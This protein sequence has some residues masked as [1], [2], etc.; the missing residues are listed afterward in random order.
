MPLE[1][2]YTSLQVGSIVL[3]GLTFIVGGG[4]IFTGIKVNRRQAILIEGLKRQNLE[5]ES[6]LEAERTT[7][8][9]LERSITPRQFPLT[10]IGG[11][12]NWDGLAQFA[13]S[14][15]T[16]EYLPDWEAR[17]AALQI[18]NLLKVAGWNVIE[19]KGNPDLEGGFWDGIVA[20]PYRPIDFSQMGPGSEFQRRVEASD[21]LV[22]FLK[23][24][25]WVA[26][27]QAGD[28]NAAQ[29]IRVAI[30]FKPNPYFVPPELKRLRE[31]FDRVR[32]EG[33]RRA[34]EI[35]ER[36]LRDLK[37]QQEKERKLREQ[38]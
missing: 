4:A 5:T 3:L 15:A 1:V 38:H 31:E 32:E 2:W 29:I 16:V 21:S 24:Y 14:N 30:G 8:L 35:E 11:K 37:I 10:N 6:K 19:V 13:G 27:T 9:E 22:A 18:A 25:N 36:A 23:G 17:R 26:R 33:A 34:K 20:M 7:R 12:H 28:R